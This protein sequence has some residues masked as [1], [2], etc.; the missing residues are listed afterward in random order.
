MR[1]IL[2]ASAGVSSALRTYNA[3]AAPLAKYGATLSLPR[4]S[5]LV[6]LKLLAKV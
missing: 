6:R 4:D 2:A 1:N 5:A 3:Q